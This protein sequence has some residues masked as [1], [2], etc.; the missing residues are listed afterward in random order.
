MGFPASGDRAL[1]CHKP[2][3]FTHTHVCVYVH[4]TYLH[5]HTYVSV[6]AHKGPRL[7]PHCL[8]VGMAPTPRAHSLACYLAASLPP[9]TPPSLS[10]SPASR[11]HP[12]MLLL[13]DP[14]HT[15]S[16]KPSAPTC[17]KEVGMGGGS[18]S[19]TWVCDFSSPRGSP[20]LFQGG[21]WGSEQLIHLLLLQ[22]RGSQDTEGSAESLAVT[23][24]PHLPRGAPCLAFGGERLPK[25]GLH[26]TQASQCPWSRRRTK[27]PP[28]ARFPGHIGAGD[29]RDPSCPGPVKAR[30]LLGLL[31]LSLALEGSRSGAALL[32]KPGQNPSILPTQS[33]EFGSSFSSA[34]SCPLSI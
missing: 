13:G 30:A 16:Q 7:Q 21:A 6:C 34:H 2:F 17:W 8:A 26:W 20:L 27:L 15:C 32:A 31:R 11:S 4:Y 3:T 22:H 1:A 29:T 9:Q 33:V 19:D 5:V 28:P 18:A 12:S 25:L 10:P 23:P 24:C 14:V